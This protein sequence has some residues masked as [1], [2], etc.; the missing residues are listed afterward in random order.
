M[1]FAVQIQIEALTRRLLTG[2]LGIQE[3]PEERFDWF[4]VTFYSIHN[5]SF[6][7][8]QANYS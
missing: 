3:N 8:L 1:A 2:D 6:G 4:C 5:L 7:I